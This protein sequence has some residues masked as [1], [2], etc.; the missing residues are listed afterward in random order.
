MAGRLGVHESLLAVTWVY[1]LILHRMTTPGI[2]QG[3][4]LSAYLGLLLVVGAMLAIGVLISALLPHA[5][6]PGS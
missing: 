5:W 1:P 4:L 3:V 6:W 2:D